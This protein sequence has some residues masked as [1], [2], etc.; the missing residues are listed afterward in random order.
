MKQL[1]IY[2]LAGIGI[3]P[4][5]LGLAALAH[6]ISSLSCIFFD[7][8]P[9]FNWHP[10]LMMDFS[11]LQ[12]PFYA[13]LVTLTDPSS[14][15]SFLA[16]LKSMGRLL[17]FAIKENNYISRRE[18]N[19]YCQWVADQLPALRFNHK[20]TAVS[21]NEQMACYEIRANNKLH[22]EETTCYARRL[23]IG[24]GPIPFQPYFIPPVTPDTC[25]FHA[26]AYLPNKKK[27]SGKRGVTIIGSGQSAAEIFYDLLSDLEEFPEG[28]Q[29]FTRA[30]RFY[31][32]E[33]GKFSFEMTSPDYIRYFY[34]LPTHKKN[35]VLQKQQILYKGINSQLIS[36]IYDLMYQKTIDRPTIKANT[37]T[38]CELRNMEQTSDSVYKL[39]FHHDELLQYFDH[40]T[41]ACILATG[42][43]YKV[44]AFLYPIRDRIRLNERQQY[45]VQENYCISIPEREIFIQNG[46]L[47]THGFTAPDL[48]MG[49]HRN[50]VILNEI[51][52]HDYY[53]TEKNTTFQTFGIPQAAG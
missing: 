45:A 19:N 3:G 17:Q 36:A 25:H 49:P 1:K 6:P 37:Y 20:I 35:S 4:F 7:Q 31:P 42:Y 24:T 28:I 32:M 5:N 48:G 34:H 16:Y 22:Q 14:P 10:G 51:L 27:L 18:Y 13:D 46:E 33:T 44:P 38:N 43:T 40:Q 11:T 2:D 29:W 52:G 41:D 26:S 23:V 39:T 47:H 21:Y 12:V 15:F 9:S 50:A 53:Q 30:N 8:Q